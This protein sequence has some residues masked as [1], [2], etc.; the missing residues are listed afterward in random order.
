MP[1]TL[2]LPAQMC[3]TVTLVRAGAPTQDA[4]GNIVDGPEMRTDIAGCSLQPLQG[5]DS[6]ESLGATF[7]QVTTRWRLFAP[8][9]VVVGS[10]DRIQQGA[11][12]FTGVPDDASAVLDFQ[13]DGDPAFWPGADGQPHHIEMMLKKWSG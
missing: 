2:G 9:G 13:V 5:T 8:P 1:R 11:D 10:M 6:I 3:Q 12:P 4:N 7:D